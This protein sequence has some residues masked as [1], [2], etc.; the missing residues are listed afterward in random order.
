MAY[1][2]LIVV[3]SRYLLPVEE[4][5][6]FDKLIKTNLKLTKYPLWTVNDY[7]YRH[8]YCAE[9]LYIISRSVA[10]NCYYNALHRI[11][12]YFSILFINLFRSYN[13]LMLKSRV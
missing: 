11:F 8:L 10:G 13:K 6:H 2:G 7:V 12:C 9:T 4:T 3:I 5:R 1:Y